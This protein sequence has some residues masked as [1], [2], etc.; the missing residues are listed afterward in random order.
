MSEPVL[1]TKNN[2]S[3]LSRIFTK[4]SRDLAEMEQKSYLSR[5]Y[6]MKSSEGNENAFADK[7]SQVDIVSLCDRWTSYD[8][9]SC[10]RHTNTDSIG[11]CSVET[12][13]CFSNRSIAI[14]TDPLWNTQRVVSI[15]CSTDTPDVYD[16]F[17][18]LSG[19]PYDMYMN[20]EA[21]LMKL[22]KSRVAHVSDSAFNGEGSIT[23]VTDTTRLQDELLRVEAR[24]IILRKENEALRSLL[25]L[26]SRPLPPAPVYP[27]LL[28]PI[29]ARPQPALHAL[30]QPQLSAVDHAPVRS[31]TQPA[32][33][34]LPQPALPSRSFMVTAQQLPVTSTRDPGSPVIGLLKQGDVIV[35][36]RSPEKDGRLPLKPR[37]WVTGGSL[38]M[39]RLLI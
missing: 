18:W 37:G 28:T 34:A 36:F 10:E 27:P 9:S 3:F 38:Y 22:A 21:L 31:T 13:T 2:G 25:S 8:S 7:G 39:R 29:A 14:E 4:P 5:E 11:S 19:D 30:P 6:T 15:E 23:S 20:I 17:Y 32:L 1:K 35:A 24:A 33:H 16:A 12:E 26:P